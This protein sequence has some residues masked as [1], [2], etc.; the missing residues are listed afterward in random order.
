MLTIREQLERR[1][2]DALAPQAAK[3]A[4]SRGRLRAEPDDDVR[5]AFQRDRDRIIHSKAF[6][7]LKHKTQV[8]FAPMGDHYRTRLTHTLEVSQIARTIA[9]VLRLHE[10]LTEAIAL[11]HDLGHTPFGHAGERVLDALMPGG[12]N[13]YVQSLRVV[14]VLENDGRGLNLTWE[15]RD[16]IAKHSK[17]KSGSPVGMTDAQRAGTVEGQIMRVADLIAY[18]NHDIDDAVRAGLFTT[19]DLPSDPIRVL[20]GSSSARIGT[21]V[22][23]VVTE[24]L[25]GG[26]SEIRMSDPVLAAVL[27]LRAFLFS[28]V[29]ENLVATAEF[30]KASDVLN[31]LWEKVRERPDEFLDRR[32]IEAEGL[33]AAAR[34]FVAGMTDRYAVRLFEQLF[35]PKPWTSD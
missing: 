7:R 34:D 24:T 5:P 8:F 18:V 30:R 35:I 10:E 9:K 2:R 19:A 32:T 21:L 15:V 31:G 4:A 1:E 25:A 20:G 23:D 29:Y 3:S 11:G 28:A 26:L 16:G 33:D 14:D 6:R 22:K 13:H 17:G 12:F 27:D